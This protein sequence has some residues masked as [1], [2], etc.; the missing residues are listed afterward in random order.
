MLVLAL[1]EGRRLELRGE[2]LL[3]GELGEPF[4]VSGISELML[5]GFLFAFSLAR[6]TSCV[7][8]MIRS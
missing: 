4:A 7:P 8:K 3:A 6:F 1:N 5:T 2:L